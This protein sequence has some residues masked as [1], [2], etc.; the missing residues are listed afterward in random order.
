MEYLVSSDDLYDVF[1]QYLKK[2]RPELFNLDKDPSINDDKSIYAYEFSEFVSYKLFFTYFIEPNI[3]KSS[4]NMDYYPMLRVTSK[5][6]N[7]LS[8]LFGPYYESLMIKWFQDQYKLPVKT[9][10]S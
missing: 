8:G 4:A 2:Y 10:R 5:L 6:Y 7:E 9:I 3:G 1:H